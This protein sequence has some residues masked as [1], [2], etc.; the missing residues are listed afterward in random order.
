MKTPTLHT[1]TGSRRPPQIKPLTMANYNQLTPPGDGAPEPLDM[2]L[3]EF[4]NAMVALQM[5]DLNSSEQSLAKARNT[6][7][8]VSVAAFGCYAHQARRR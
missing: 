5:Q 2:I 3:G 4:N 1:T 8:I 6:Y 7:R